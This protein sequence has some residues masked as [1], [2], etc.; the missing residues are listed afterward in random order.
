[1]PANSEFFLVVEFG[2]LINGMNYTRSRCRYQ[3]MI[4]NINIVNT[5]NFSHIDIGTI[6]SEIDPYHRVDI[7]SDTSKTDTILPIY[8]EIGQYLKPWYHRIMVSTHHFSYKFQNVPCR[9]SIIQKIV[10]K[11]KETIPYC[12]PL[13][14]KLT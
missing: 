10:F 13:T 6:C 14:G 12:V 7:I 4:F 8:I 2:K 9:P 1:M 5:G 3:P 11:H